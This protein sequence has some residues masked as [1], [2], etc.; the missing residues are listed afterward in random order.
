[1]PE[2]KPEELGINKDH[3]D[4]AAAAQGVGLP[5]MKETLQTSDVKVSEPDMPSP[6]E[7][8]LKGKAAEEYHLRWVSTD[9]QRD[10]V[11]LNRER[12]Y[13]PVR[14]E[15]AERAGVYRGYA[16]ADGIP[17][18][19]DTILMKCKKESF[20]ERKRKQKEARAAQRKRIKEQFAEEVRKE[21]GD[22]LSLGEVKVSSK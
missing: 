9:P 5:P 21:S 17:R 16:G 15:E 18:W 6:G 13:E 8:S 10:R 22:R 1:M 11:G 4:K 19:G 3:T 20:T 12:G 14:K 7:V 2:V